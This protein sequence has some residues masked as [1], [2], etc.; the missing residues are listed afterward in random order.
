MAALTTERLAP[1]Q[2]RRVA[3]EAGIGPGD[4]LGPVI[5]AL[6]DAVDA[7]TD[8]PADCARKF[9]AVDARLSA[10][11]AKAEALAGGHIARAAAA[12]LPG[13]VDRLVVA[14]YWWL[15]VFVGV[16]LAGGI[17][18]GYWWGD[19]TRAEQVF[20]MRA[21]MDVA[22]TGKTAAAWA[23]LMRLN[24]TNDGL[25]CT[26]APLKAGG[27]GCSFTLWTTKPPPPP[28]PPVR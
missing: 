22:L 18:G 7:V 11:L 23:A 1:A 5:D 24:V 2:L 14:K 10:I 19:R 16:I 20:E 12:E 17:Y 25:L 26:P 15:T 13:A 8:L 6:A 21:V 28:P 3:T 4:P 9:D 27:E